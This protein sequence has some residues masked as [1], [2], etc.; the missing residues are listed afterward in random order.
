M[1]TNYEKYRL[2][3]N[4]SPNTVIHEVRLIQNMLNHINRKYNKTVALHDIR[5]SDIREYLDYQQTLGL[6]K[7]TI[8]R[9]VSFIRQ[10]FNYLWLESIIPIDYM[11]KF[12]YEIDT[13]EK[14]PTKINYL[15]QDLL[16]K[17]SDLLRSHELTLTAKLIFI[18]YMKGIRLRDIVKLE[19]ADF[20]DKGDLIEFKVVLHNGFPIEVQFTDVDEI[21]VLLS[22][23]ERSLFRSTAFLF[24]SK[25]NAD[26]IQLRMSSVNDYNIALT[27]YIGFPIRSEEIRVVY[28]YYLY[29]VKDLDIEII[30]K[31]L[32]I[33]IDN[34]VRL[35]K[36]GLERLSQVDY[37]TN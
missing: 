24:T 18:F 20:N 5:P 2:R 30:Q 21:S 11:T 3:N 12:K 29:K 23:F 16:D 1:I 36:Q 32:G 6:E 25:K 28:V 13:E 15:Y 34:T 22:G 14:Q 33:S 31:S 7:S 10:W 26:Y 35:L 4:I 9:K 8:M 19:I 37:N 27:K 17:K